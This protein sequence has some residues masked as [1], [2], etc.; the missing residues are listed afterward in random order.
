MTGPV[1]APGGPRRQ[2]GLS[3]ATRGGLSA[4]ATA[5]LAADAESAGFTAFFVAERAADALSVCQSAAAA[6]S[7]IGIGTAVLNVRPRHPALTAASAAAVDEAAGGRFLLGLG[8]ANPGLNEGMLGLPPVPPVPFMREYVGIVRRVLAGDP[9]PGPD[10]P[11]EPVAHRVRGYRL[12][13]PPPRPDIPILLAAM[14]PRMLGLAGAVADGVLLSL[15]TP[16]TLPGSVDM[17]AKGAAAAGRSMRDLLV[18]CVLP[19]CLTDDEERSRRTGRE[20]VVGY[21]QHPSAARL[22]AA[23]GFA[24]ELAVAARLLARGDRA[25]ALGSVTDE[26][27][28]AF[29]LRGS[30]AA[31]AERLDAC[32]AAGVDLP[33]LFPVPGDG[34]W[35]AAVR[36]T[37]EIAAGGLTP[38]PRREDRP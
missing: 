22:F 23:S 33:V 18:A 4:A 7:R 17:V 9:D 13:R 10:G 14:L 35:H 5:A 28:D 30:P 11:G 8:L 32:R 6:T 36:H 20:L 31:V 27:V 3:V 34:D 25:G 12:D 37:V 2:L 1:R 21:A 29:L 19:C 16:A 24:E 26:M 15:T 38:T